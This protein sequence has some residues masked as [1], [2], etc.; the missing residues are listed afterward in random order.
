MNDSVQIAYLHPNTVSHSFMASYMG[1]F[2]HDIRNH[3]RLT[4]SS[5]AIRCSAMQMIEARNKAAAFFLDE[6]DAGWLFM[7]D[8][9]MGFSSDTL[10]RLV[11]ASIAVNRGVVG[12][13]CFGNEETKD[14]GYGGWKI[15][16]FPTIYDMVD[17]DGLIGYSVRSRY[18]DNELLKVDA[19]G[20]A[21]LL[22]PREAF[23]KVRST[24][25]DIWF[26]Q[27]QYNNGTLISEDLSFCYR[28]GR[29]GIPIY[30]HTG[31]KTTHHKSIWLGESYY[32]P[33]ERESS[34]TKNLD[35]D[36]NS[37]SAG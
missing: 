32:S 4:H 3:R 12:A 30:V 11:D 24:D 18:Q 14:D 34:G 16:P 35:I 28:L 37:K 21:C 36:T 17:D 20:A 10:D 7:I 25:G 26:N 5:L 6:T 15:R 22:V 27:V 2:T 13:L 1:L 23:E 31:I 8:T 33:G 19:T 29:E 9:D